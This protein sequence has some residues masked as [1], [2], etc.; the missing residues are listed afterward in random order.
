MMRNRIVIGLGVAAS[1]ALSGCS[2]SPEEALANRWPMLEQ[3]CTEC[4]SD[5]EQAGGMSLEGV[6]PAEVAANPQVWEQVVR[7]LRG[8]VMPPP[9]GAHPAVDQVNQF[10]AALEA[11]LDAAA[12]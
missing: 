9:G 5:A 2:E 3:Y 12:A 8:S 7:R 11:N 1:L 6:T 4:H 10:V